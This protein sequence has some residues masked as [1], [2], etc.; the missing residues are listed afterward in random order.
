MDEREFYEERTELKVHS[1]LCPHCN[2]QN[3]YE[4][5]W[6]VRR[7][8]SQ[9]PRGCDEMDR[10]RFAKAKSYM[11]RRDDVLGCKNIRCRKR[12]EIT[13]LQSVADLETTPQ[14]NAED[15]AA[16]IRAA[17]GRRTLG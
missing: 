6:L 8:R 9:A 14:G 12:F 11:L 1:L 7:K 5:H 4:L 2:Q 3:D 13:G 16:R 15:R 17:F 10:A